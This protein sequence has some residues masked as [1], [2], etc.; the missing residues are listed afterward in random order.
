MPDA[1]V[2]VSPAVSVIRDGW[3]KQLLG[4]K[5]DPID[6]SS[7]DQPDDQYSDPDKKI[8]AEAY[9]ETDLFL[10]KLGYMD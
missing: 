2:M 4:K 7:A 3:F 9:E 8:Q 1:L 10:K 5:G 6:S